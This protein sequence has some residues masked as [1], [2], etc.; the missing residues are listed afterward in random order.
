MHNNEFKHFFSRL[1]SF[2]DSVLPLLF[3]ISVILSF[4]E[5]PIAALTMVCALIHELGHIILLILIS[6]EDFKLR[7]VISGLRISDQ[8][9]KSY[10]DELMLYLSGPTINILFSAISLFALPY[11]REFAITFCALNFATAISNLLP[12]EGYDGYGAL[13]SVLLMRG[14]DFLSEKILPI[15]S[16]F[17]I[18][19]LCVFS[20][21]F[22]D[23]FG[24]GYWIFFVFSAA[25]LKKLDCVL[26]NVNN[27]I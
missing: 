17:T 11:H 13:K 12:I 23:R 5:L 16:F 8:R 22:I 15:I 18:L 26:K 6:G 27:E 20:L 14:N 9:M 1:L 2:F 25:T 3:W 7:G 4:D 10:R 19:L 24:E 21:Y